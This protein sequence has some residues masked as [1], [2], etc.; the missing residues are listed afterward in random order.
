[1]MRT[2]EPEP[3]PVVPVPEAP[4]SEPMLIDELV[5]QAVPFSS[6]VDAGGSEAREP[7]E[8]A[9]SEHTIPGPW[10]ADSQGV[11]ETPSGLAIAEPPPIEDAEEVLPP[12]PAGP[13]DLAAYEEIIRLRYELRDAQRTIDRLRHTNRKLREALEYEP[14]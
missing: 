14:E 11:V 2:P 13:M 5:E 8:P 10:T 9:D 7:S 12:Q 4:P 1:M 6:E 3:E